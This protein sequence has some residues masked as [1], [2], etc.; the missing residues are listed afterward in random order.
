MKYLGRR[1]FEGLAFPILIS[2]F[3]A[4]II[5]SGIYANSY[6]LA[7]V[8]F[9]ITFVYNIYEL[10]KHL[11]AVRRR[12]VFY[13]TN[14]TVQAIILAITVIFA[15]FKLG[16]IFTYFFMQYTVFQML[17]VPRVL[18]AVLVNLIYALIILLTPKFA[19]KKR[20]KLDM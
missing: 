4:I 2:L 6:H 12:K 20:T 10:P 11:F 3:L 14:F 5:V 7:V 13:K 18:S 1:L 8:A 17:G 16:N 15:I 19:M 9:L